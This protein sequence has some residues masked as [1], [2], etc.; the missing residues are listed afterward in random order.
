M[1]LSKLLPFIT[2]DKVRCVGIEQVILWPN[3]SVFIILNVLFYQEV[4]GYKIDNQVTLYTVAVLEY[5]AA[6]ILKVFNIS[7]FICTVLPLHFCMVYQK[8]SC[9]V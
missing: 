1:L 8:A 9:A 4:L 2:Y 6:D 3:H 5:I 7:V